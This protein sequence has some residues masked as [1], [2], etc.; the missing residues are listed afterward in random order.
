MRSR[1][2][3]QQDEPIIAPPAKT[4][5]SSGVGLRVS[6]LSLELDGS[7]ILQEV[8]LS[9]PEQGINVLIGPSGA[10]KSTLLRCLNLLQQSWRGDVQVMGRDIR[11]WPGGEDALRRTVGLIA[12][13][14]SLFPCSVAQNVLFG[15][16]GKARKQVSSGHLEQVLRQAALWDEVKTRLHDQASTL[17][18]G[19]QQRLCIA[20]AL[21]LSPSMLLLDEPTA[22]LDPRSRRSIEVSM[23]KLAEQM[24]LL[25]V[26]HD[27]EQARRL[28]GQTVFMCDGRLIETGPSASFFARPDRVESREFLR[29]S[30]CD[31]S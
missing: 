18:L 31:C 16:K 30:V 26:T 1:L 8:S 10:G 25:C 13:K 6:H 17:S 3:K 22:S 9:M 21:A 14:P 12:Q 29:W 11:S 5:N 2:I 4:M 19:Q 23:L 28:G 7:P 27:M 20:R 24:P 15:L